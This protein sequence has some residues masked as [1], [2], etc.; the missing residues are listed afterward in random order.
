MNRVLLLALLLPWCTAK[1][2]AQDPKPAVERAVARINDGQADAVRDELPSMLA[3]Y[4]NHPGVLYV[5]ALLTPEGAEAVRTYQSIVDNYPSSEW[6]DDALYRVYQ[7]YYALGLYRTADLKMDQLR[8]DY[9]SSPYLG[10]GA[11]AVPPR[12]LET[13]T[14]ADPAPVPP[15]AQAADTVVSPPDL[16][17]QETA[18]RYVLQVGAFTQ[19]ANAEKQK[20][21]FEGLGYPVEVITKVVGARTM[22]TVLVGSYGT[23]D[24]AKT[25][26]AELRKKQRIDAIVISR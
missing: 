14:P 11:A 5:Q 22:F 9:P 6:A 1:L 2:P 19:L 24:D 20:A 10:G 26:G 18:V 8:R 23:Y 16:P 13:E 4:P 21:L 7:F 17:V 3:Q 15:A 25:A 12:P